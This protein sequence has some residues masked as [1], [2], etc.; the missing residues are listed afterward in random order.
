MKSEHIAT[1]ILLVSLFVVSPVSA[2][3]FASADQSTASPASSVAEVPRLIKFSGTLLDEQDRPLAG[4]VGVTF[5]LYAQQT[6]GASL[7]LET[8]NVNPDA[9]GKY[10]ILLG[11]NSAHGVPVELFA[12]AEARWLGFRWA[13]SRK[14]KE[15]CSSVCPM[16]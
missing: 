13:S 8:Q 16:P 2:E 1:G 4:P 12:S 11:A 15:S 7:W 3:T 10:T 14:K 9:N 5:A 6:G